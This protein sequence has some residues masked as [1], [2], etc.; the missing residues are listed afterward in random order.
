[1]VCDKT[2]DSI[3]SVDLITGTVGD[4][5]TSARDKISNN[6]I[7]HLPIISESKK[8]LGIIS[9]SDILRVDF[10]DRFSNREKSD[11]LLN[12]MVKIPDI[13][14][15]NVIKLHAGD[16]VCYAIELFKNNL[17]HALPVVS[18]DNTLIGMI[19]PND[20]ISYLYYHAA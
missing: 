16:Q 15:I 7:H 3:M 17:F 10:S 19:T 12:K 8:L 5:F 14:T 20:I 4:S 2:V 13:M 1:M 18:L 11:L 9:E 6:F